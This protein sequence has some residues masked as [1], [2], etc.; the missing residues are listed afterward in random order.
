[1]KRA[2]CQDKVIKMAINGAIY[3]S[4]TLIKRRFG[5][6]CLHSLKGQVSFYVLGHIKDLVY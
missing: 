2:R 5:G 4:I 6:T 1:M 3:L